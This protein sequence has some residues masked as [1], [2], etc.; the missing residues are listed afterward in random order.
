MNN[1]LKTTNK[2]INIF[3]TTN[4]LLMKMSRN[5]VDFFS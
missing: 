1:N 4:Y 3:E 5:K 2:K